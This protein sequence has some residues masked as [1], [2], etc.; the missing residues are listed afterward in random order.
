[1]KGTQSK[2]R[3]FDSNS[4]LP[5]E[6]LMPLKKISAL[7]IILALSGLIGAMGQWSTGGS[8]IY[9][10]NTWNVGIGNNSPTALLHAAKLMTEPTITQQNLGGTGGA[11]YTM[12]D[13]VCGAIWKFKAT[14]SGGFKVRDH[15]NSLDVIVIERKWTLTLPMWIWPEASIPSTVM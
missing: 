11:T 15:A 13:Q 4:I 6:K 1:M 7:I 9:N 8:N 3:H 10:T 5:C 12:I 14:N 2:T